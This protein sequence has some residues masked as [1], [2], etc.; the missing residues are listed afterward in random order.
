MLFIVPVVIL[1]LL[2]LIMAV[3]GQ[4]LFGMA[5]CGVSFLYIAKSFLD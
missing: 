2:G 1:N 3:A 5:L 4:P